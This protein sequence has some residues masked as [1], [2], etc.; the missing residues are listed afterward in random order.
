[1]S[2]PRPIPSPHGRLGVRPRR[3]PLRHLR[4]AAPRL[5][6]TTL[7]G[8]ES[9]TSAGWSVAHIAAIVGLILFPLGYGALRGRLEGTRNEKTAFMA[10]TIGSSARP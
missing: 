10:A 5:D 3:R 8:A 7:E 1:M 9:W 2:K 4:G 6:Q